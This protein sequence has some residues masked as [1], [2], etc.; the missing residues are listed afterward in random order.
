VHGRCR[1]SSKKKEGEKVRNCG[2]RE[3]SEKWRTS[4]PPKRSVFFIFDSNELFTARLPSTWNCPFPK[5]VSAKQN[6]HRKKQTDLVALGRLLRWGGEAALGQEEGEVRGVGV[7]G[8]AEEERQGQEAEEEKNKEDAPR[9]ANVEVTRRRKRIPVLNILLREALLAFE[10]TLL[11]GLGRGVVKT[12]EGNRVDGTKRR[13]R[14][15]EGVL[16]A[17]SKVLPLGV[18]LDTLERGSDPL[19]KR[20]D[21][22]KLSDAGLLVDLDGGLDLASD[23]LLESGLL[24]LEADEGELEVVLLVDL[25]LELVVD[26]VVGEV[27]VLLGEHLGARVFEG[28]DAGLELEE[29][30]LGSLAL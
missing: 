25:L 28:V 17:G 8:V 9:L 2:R 4:L 19:V 18:G 10:M 13:V 16:L 11:E 5:N 3:K 14:V 27:R 15:D 21:L 20:L 26:D 30:A 22:L 1:R 7:G 24:L 23:T 12:R 6:K 29:V